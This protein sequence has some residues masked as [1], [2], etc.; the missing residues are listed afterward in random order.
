[1]T[2]PVR[3]A[4]DDEYEQQL[5]DLLGSLPDHEVEELAALAEAMHAESNAD[6][7]WLGDVDQLRAWFERAEWNE[8]LHPR[9]PHGEFA[10]VPGSKLLHEVE[11]AAGGGHPVDARRDKL[12]LAG[13]IHLDPGEHL[14][15]SSKV[16]SD[17]GSVR[18]AATDKDGHRLLRLGVGNWAFG[19]QNKS[20][21]TVAWTGGPDRFDEHQKARDKRGEQH[22][23]LEEKWDAAAPGPERDAIEQ[24]MEA[25]E[26]AGS[27][28]EVIGG[29]HTMRLDAAG[30]AQMRT[31]L[32]DALPTKQAESDHINGLYDELDAL[33]ARLAYFHAKDARDERYTPDE[34]AE[35]AQ[36]LARRKDLD[37]ILGVSTKRGPTMEPSIEGEIPGEWGTLHYEAYVDEPS[38]GP[39]LNLAV[40]PHGQNMDD[41]LAEEGTF[42]LD[43]DQWQQLLKQLDALAPASV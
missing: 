22:E 3:P 7:S 28:G 27:G 19:R 20:E 4:S 40:V 8:H 30:V 24:Q 41:V 43:S 14:I 9:D 1:M 13:K 2:Q 23:A 11:H 34:K 26:E 25:L 39:R 42:T 36:V 32:S 16:A 10:H 18:L 31:A 6:R 33:D 15:G 38:E 35:F 29:G 21:G 12:K 5:M 17:D 37:R